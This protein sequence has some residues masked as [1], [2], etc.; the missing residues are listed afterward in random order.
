MGLRSED[1]F[2]LD[3]YGNEWGVC[4]ACGSEARAEEVCCEDGEVVPDV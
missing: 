4:N 3:E 1:G 2:F